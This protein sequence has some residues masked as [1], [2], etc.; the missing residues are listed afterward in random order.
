[1]NFNS[2]THVEC[3]PT[4]SYLT[5]LI[6]PFQLTHSR[7]VR[8]RETGHQSGCRNFNSRTHVECD[9]LQDWVEVRYDISTHALTWSATVRRQWNS[10]SYGISTHALTWSATEDG[11]LNG[12][13]N[14]ISTHALTWSATMGLGKTYV[15]SEISTHALTWSATRSANRR[16]TKIKISTHALTWSATVRWKLTG[17]EPINF[18]SRTHVECDPLRGTAGTSKTFQL[19]HSR[20][21]RRDEMFMKYMNGEISTHALTWSTTYARSCKVLRQEFQ[22]THSRGVRLMRSNIYGGMKKFQLTHSRGVR[23]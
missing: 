23:P 4:S 19:T 18:N 7:G 17:S 8:L 13:G 15:G 21:V 14:G 2:R 9:V 6:F 16:T 5:S 22:L 1:M 12:D 10:I 11:Y 20:G 3:D